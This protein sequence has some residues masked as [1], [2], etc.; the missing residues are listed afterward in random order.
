MYIS[1]RNSN[2]GTLAY[3]LR[4]RN[5][6]IHGL[7]GDEAC[8][9]YDNNMQKQLAANLNS[10]KRAITAYLKANSTTTPT[11]EA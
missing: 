5:K 3:T 7:M 9:W 4:Y 1:H 8:Y 2:N 11:T 10:A 6:Y